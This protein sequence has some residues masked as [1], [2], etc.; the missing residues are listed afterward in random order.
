MLEGWSKL[1]GLQR[2]GGG[3]AQKSKERG[4]KGLIC[5]PELSLGSFSTCSPPHR[6][7]P[8]RSLSLSPSPLREASLLRRGKPGG[9]YSREPSRREQRLLGG[10]LPLSRP[11]ASP[12]PLRAHPACVC[13]PGP[14]MALGGHSPEWVAG[15]GKGRV[16]RQED[17]DRRPGQR[18]EPS[19]GCLASLQGPRRVATA[20][21]IC[22]SRDQGQ[23]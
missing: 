8:S 10:P 3:G 13:A 12:Q 7:A 17:G 16:W 4:K 23:D 9:L 11:R 2:K 21:N 22:L 5:P 15:L 6:E 19:Q 18:Q 1:Q 14:S 20:T